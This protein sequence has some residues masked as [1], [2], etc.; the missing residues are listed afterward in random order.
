[1]FR[2]AY[3]S[4]SKI[5]RPRQFATYRTKTDKPNVIQKLGK[6]HNVRL[7]KFMQNLYKEQHVDLTSSRSIEETM[8]RIRSAKGPVQTLDTFKKFRRLNPQAK[9]A[10]E[11]WLAGSEYVVLMK[12]VETLSQV[13]GIGHARAAEL[14]EVGATTIEDLRKPQYYDLLTN[15]QQAFLDFQDDLNKVSDTQAAHRVQETVRS[16]LKP[17]VE[18][19]LVGDHRRGLQQSISTQLLIIDPAHE[20][21]PTPAS[22]GNVASYSVNRLEATEGNMAPESIELLKRRGILAAELRCSTHKWSGL[23]RVSGKNIDGDWE[24]QIQRVKGIKE[25]QGEFRRADLVFVPAKSR[26]AALIM[27]TGDEFMVNIIRKKA[28]ELGLKFNEFGLWRLKVMGEQEE[29]AARKPE[30]W[31][32]VP[33]E[34]EEDFFA[35]LGLEWIEPEKRNLGYLQSGGPK[36]YRRKY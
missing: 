34:T 36:P 20:H 6:E 19:I 27:C 25:H 11:N 31:E 22:T 10:I 35:E 23:V 1:M 3:A 33:T 8:D 21:L 14:V 26:A 28:D 13:P 2:Q 24:S 15:A 7:I 5:V 18:V 9:T 12:H 30:S 16:A 32:L 4:T 17:T 29:R